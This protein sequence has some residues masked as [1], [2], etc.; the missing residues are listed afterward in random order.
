MD[1]GATNGWAPADVVTAR[2]ILAILRQ[3][4]DLEPLPEADPHAVAQ[5][6]RYGDGAGEVGVIASV[7]Q[8]FCRHCTRM[9]LSTEGMLYTC[10]FATEGFDVKSLL[11]SSLPDEGLRERIRA[12]WQQRTDQ[13]SQLRFHSQRTLRPIEMS[14]IGG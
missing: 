6:Y 5:V 14:Y 3:H 4:W 2:E 9:R 8:P 13:Y 10:L 11:R 7:T 1:V 12:R